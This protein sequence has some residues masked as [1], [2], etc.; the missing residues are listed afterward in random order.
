MWLREMH[1]QHRAL[2]VGSIEVAKSLRSKIRQRRQVLP[3]STL[4][5]LQWVSTQNF[6]ISAGFV[7][8][9]YYQV[10]DLRDSYAHQRSKELLESLALNGLLC[11]GRRTAKSSFAKSGT[12]TFTNYRLSSK[13]KK[14]LSDHDSSRSQ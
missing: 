2:T 3:E 13:A 12:Y 10:H 6:P 11:R 4:R 9:H 14:A 1:W 5:F 8:R 7:T